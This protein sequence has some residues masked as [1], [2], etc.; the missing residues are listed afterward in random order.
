MINKLLSGR[1]RPLPVGM[2]EFNEFA[3]RIFEIG[4]KYA[5]E[6]SMKFALASILIHAD[7]KHGRLP[8]KYFADRLRKSAANQVASQV[9]QEIKMRQAAALEAESK[10][11]EATTTTVEASNVKLE[12]T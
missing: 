11:V 5:D 10:P 4:G 2:T 1:N 7:A 8:D 12:Q 3:T 6:D 9:F